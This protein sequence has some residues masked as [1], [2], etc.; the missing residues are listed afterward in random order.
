MAQ[1]ARILSLLV[2]LVFAAFCVFGFIAS[3]EPPGNWAARILCGFAG[4]GCF[5][6]IAV[7]LWLW[8]YKSAGAERRA[9]SP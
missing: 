3:F 9:E 4:C 2:H 8:R 6:G 7:L 5:A 1:L